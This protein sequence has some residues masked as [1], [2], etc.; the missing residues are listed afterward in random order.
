MTTITA[1]KGQYLFRTRD[2]TH[3]LGKM[4]M[5]FY[6]SETTRAQLWDSSLVHDQDDWLNTE[7]LEAK[8]PAIV[9][10]QNSPRIIIQVSRLTR[11]YP[12]SRFQAEFWSSPPDVWFILVLASEG[13]FQL[14]QTVN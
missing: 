11:G 5:P 10:L 2:Y 8:L 13:L 14:W 6:F 4:P 3:H 1:R 7:G 9:P 12:L